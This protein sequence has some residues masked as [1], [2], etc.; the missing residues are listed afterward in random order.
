MPKPRRRSRRGSTS[1]CNPVKWW[2]ANAP[3][4]RGLAF[5]D[6]MILPHMRLETTWLFAPILSH[7]VIAPSSNTHGSACCGLHDAGSLQR[8]RTLVAGQSSELPQP[9][10]AQ[11]WPKLFGARTMFHI[12]IDISE[13]GDHVIKA[14][15]EFY[16]QSNA[17]PVRFRVMFTWHEPLVLSAAEFT[18]GNIS[19]ACDRTAMTRDYIRAEREF[20]KSFGAEPRPH[21]S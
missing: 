6:L 9:R 1:R 12:S 14:W 4:Y 2:R 5:R 20:I 13:T 3:L 17:D 8:V 10:A 19:R 7:V 15:P 11:M 16:D 18:Y 21:T